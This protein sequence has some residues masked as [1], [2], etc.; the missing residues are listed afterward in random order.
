MRPLTFCLYASKSDS[1]GERATMTWSEWLPILQ[2]HAVRGDPSDGQE[3]RRAEEGKDGAA[4]ILAE[5]PPGQSRRDANVVSLQAIGLD[6]EHHTDAEIKAALEQ[7]LPYEWCYYTTHKSGAACV[8]GETRLRVILPLAE[9]VA[10][11]QLPRLWAHLDTLTHNVRDKAASNPARLFFLPSTF[12]ARL[13]RVRHNAG[14]WLSVNECPPM[15]KSAPAMPANNEVIDTVALTYLNKLLGGLPNGVEHKTAVRLLLSGLA[16]AEPGMRH[17][18]IAQITWEIAVRRQNINAPTLRELFRRSLDAM[19]GQQQAPDFAEVWRAYADGVAKL[20]ANLE[21]KRQRAQGACADDPPYTQADLER[22][23]A[24][25]GWASVDDLQR[26]WIISRDD[27][28]WMLTDRGYTSSYRPSDAAQGVKEKCARAPIALN[29][30][31]DKEGIRWKS[32]HDLRREYGTLA[33]KV[34]VSLAA[35][36]SRFDVTAGRNTMIEATCPLR[37]L[38]IEKR[39]DDNIDR[40]L[41]LF[42]GSDYA[43]LEKWI[44][45]APDCERILCALYFEGPQGSGKTLFAQ[46]LAKLWTSGAPCP[47]TEVMSAFNEHL[48]KCPVVLGDEYVPKWSRDGADGTSSLRHQIGSINRVLTRKYRQ[49]ADL[50]GAPRFILAANNGSLLKANSVLTVDDLHAIS[51]RF[52]YL[53]LNEDA[54]RFLHS[55]PNKEKEAWEHHKIAGHV[56]ALAERLGDTVTPDERFWV[57]GDIA[58]MGRVLITSTPWTARVCEWLVRFLL[59]PQPITQK[60][61][62]LILYGEGKLLVNPQAITDGWQVY[63]AQSRVEVETA[64]VATALKTIALSRRREIHQREGQRVSYFDID[65]EAL[66]TWAEQNAIGDR[67][68]VLSILGEPPT[69]EPGGDDAE[70]VEKTSPAE[71]AELLSLSKEKEPW[72]EKVS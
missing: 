11:D 62:D 49:N 41:R 10:P 6:I 48:C 7:L 47:L 23:A 43:K 12:D 37:T 55:L 2:T 65:P 33:D 15:T 38:E 40:W 35:Q 13:A 32:I 26:R 9:P 50:Y 67:A 52:F 36:Y 3:I 68:T 66:A 20:R 22:I 54:Q 61:D 21:I 1:I 42:A 58:N 27:A 8:E 19:A 29:E 14:R 63:F 72:D 4:I 34:T 17:A 25:Q 5:I 60:H 18:R 28:F 44:A 56:L 70:V 71:L 31:T 53:G 46:G 57:E 24:M 51:V 16:F 39:F 64:S 69:R 30:I 45:C 59:N